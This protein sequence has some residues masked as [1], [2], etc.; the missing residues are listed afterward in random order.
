MHGRTGLQSE[1]PESYPAAIQLIRR[2]SICII[3]HILLLYEYDQAGPCGQ[4]QYLLYHGCDW[5]NVEKIITDGFR[6][7]LSS[8]Q[9]RSL[10][11]KK[12]YLQ[13]CRPRVVVM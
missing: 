9:R 1:L 10:F 6:K 4:G 7:E 2:R 11:G 3:F 5:Y 12:V 13:T 8:E